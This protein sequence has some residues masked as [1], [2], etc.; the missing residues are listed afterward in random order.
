MDM[1]VLFVS[2]V[3]MVLIVY[4][5][6]QHRKKRDVRPFEKRASYIEIERQLRPHQRR[7]I[8][9]QEANREKIENVV[10]QTEE[11]G[12]KIELLQS[13]IATG[14]TSADDKLF[15]AVKEMQTSQDVLLARTDELE[16]IL[17]R[18]EDPHTLS[19][20]PESLTEVAV[21]VEKQEPRIRE[22]H[23][24]RIRFLAEKAESIAG[25]V[26]ALIRNVPQGFDVPI[27][28]GVENKLNKLITRIESM[29]ES[30]RLGDALGQE[31]DR[32]D[33][34]VADLVQ[35]DVV[36]MIDEVETFSRQL[37]EQIDRL[38]A[39]TELEALS[40]QAGDSYDRNIHKAIG[41]GAGDAYTIVDL[42]FSG[43]SYKGE[44]LRPAAVIIG[45]PH[46]V[47]A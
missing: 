3:N 10:R 17:R 28:R 30:T 11:L 13:T 36:E 24:N 43:Y 23:R 31:L 16:Q 2:G 15:S 20:V 46:P 37:R 41:L 7:V 34:E 8:E 32:V 5:V 18:Q 45:D 9:I 38:L 33:E 1:V 39:V 21:S 29:I 4:L 27:S 26:G 25:A 35:H 44:V 40:P 47:E 14:K 6:I 42:K 12:I 22:E 19:A